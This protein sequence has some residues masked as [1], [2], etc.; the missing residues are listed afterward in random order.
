MPLPPLAQIPPQIAAVA[1]YEDYARE[2]MSEAAWAYL[3]GGA[4]DELT[5][6]ANRE[7]FDRIRLQPRVLGKLAGGSTA[8]ELLGVHLPYPILLAPVA[9]Q[10]LAH[11]QGELATV[12]AASAMKAAMVVSTQSSVALEDLAQAADTPLWFQLYFQA[13]RDDTLKL[14]RRAEAAGYRALVLTV[15]APVNGVRNREQRAGFSLPPGIEA[16]NLRGLRPMGQTVARA[17]ESAI[18]G[19][20]MLDHA[21]SWDDVAWLRSQTRLPIVLKG[22]LSPVD[23]RLAVEAGAAA[24]VVSNHG[25]RTLDGLPPTLEALPWVADEVQGRIPVL[26]DGGVRRGT[27][28]FK[29]VALG[30]AAVLVGR[31]YVH[32][33][34]AAGA[35]GVIHVL[36]LLRTELEIAM[37]LAGCATLADIGR[38]AL[39]P[40]AWQAPA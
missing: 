8:L 23:A 2:R 30:A 39:W 13:R 6:R 24:I 21:P 20:G 33:L 3:A 16:V 36:H 4:A 11:P 29:A 12:L 7:A 27:D 35:V 37:A 15:D 22:I 10:K 14:V 38:Q 31:G 26:M 19:S 9:Y 17:G 1:D 32:G 40:Q 5:L 25:G 28:V 18:F 34:A